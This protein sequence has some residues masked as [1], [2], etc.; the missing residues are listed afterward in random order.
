[1]HRCEYR[2]YHGKKHDRR[3]HEQRDQTE[4]TSASQCRLIQWNCR[5]QHPSRKLREPRRIT[6]RQSIREHPAA[7]A[8]YDRRDCRQG[9]YQESRTSDG[10]TMSA[11]HQRN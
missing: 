3:R 4:Q 6:H 8:T 1:M 5:D 11:Y 2:G 9:A 7:H 10:E